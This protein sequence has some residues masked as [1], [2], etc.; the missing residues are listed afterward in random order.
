MNR[1]TRISTAILATLM[2]ISTL[3]ACGAKADKAVAMTPHTTE[4]TCATAT[5]AVTET[6]STETDREHVPDD[7]PRIRKST[8]L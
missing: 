5:T 8:A 1:I 3:F 7:L 4:A 2:L 6:E